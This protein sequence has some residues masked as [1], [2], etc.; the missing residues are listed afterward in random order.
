MHTNDK[1]DGKKNNIIHWNT[2]IS[3]K[4][5]GFI[6]YYKNFK[7]SDR[8]CQATWRRKVSQDYGMPFINMRVSAHPRHNIASSASNLLSIINKKIVDHRHK[9]NL[10]K[11]RQYGFPSSRFTTVFLADITHRIREALENKCITSA[12]T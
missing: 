1:R 7:T 9:N 5:P 2:P 3:K 4:Y 12:I 8:I 10:L 6:I 11:D